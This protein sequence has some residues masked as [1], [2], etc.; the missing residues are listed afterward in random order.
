MH[1]AVE[2]VYCQGAPKG[3]LSLVAFSLVPVQNPQRCVTMLLLRRATAIPLCRP[4]RVPRRSIPDSDVQEQNQ[5]GSEWLVEKTRQPGLTGPSNGTVTQGCSGPPHHLA[6]SP[7][8][9]GT[10]AR[11]RPP[12]LAPGTPF[13]ARFGSS[14]RPARPLTSGCTAEHCCA[15]RDSV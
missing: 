1:G 8:P 10:R 4:R 12:R 13:P 14:S 3:A 11:R 9:D 7:V 15:S 5:A 6:Q 2:W